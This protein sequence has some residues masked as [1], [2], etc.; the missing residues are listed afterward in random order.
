MGLLEAKEER[1]KFCLEHLSSK[2]CLNC[3]SLSFF[4]FICYRAQTIPKTS[5]SLTTW[6]RCWQRMC[7]SVGVCVCVFVRVYVCFLCHHMVSNGG[8]SRIGACLCGLVNRATTVLGGG[9]LSCL[10]LFFIMWE[11]CCVLPVASVLVTDD[12]PCTAERIP[13]CAIRRGGG[14][15]DVAGVYFAP[16]LLRF[17]L[18]CSR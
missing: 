3:S 17:V 12:Q 10:W 5:S 14:H 7:V 8:L 18:F 9:Y 16:W 2:V 15:R 13:P 4:C 6:W 1:I 11:P